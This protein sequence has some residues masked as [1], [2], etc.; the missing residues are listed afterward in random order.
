M[1]FT[2][3]QQAA[4]D[5]IASWDRKGKF[6]LRGAAGTGKSTLMKEVI[7]DFSS[8][9]VTLLAPTGK[10]CVRL[11][12]TTGQQATTIHSA[13]Y[14]AFKNRR[15]ELK[16]S[17]RMDADQGGVAIVDE[18]SMVTER[19]ASDLE[20][21]FDGVLYIGDHYQLPPVKAA[22]WFGNQKAD[23]ELTEVLRQALDSPILSL[24]TAIR[25]GKPTPASCVSDE[26]VI[27]S[28]ATVEDM[29]GVDQVI[30][31]TNK[32]REALNSLMRGKLGRQGPIQV[33]DRLINLRNVAKGEQY[34]CNG[35]QGVVV[36]EVG[37]KWR[38]LFDGGEEVVCPI[39]TD[40][41]RFNQKY[42]ESG[43]SNRGSSSKPP[44]DLL[45]VDMA[46][47]VTGHKSQGSQWDSVLVYDDSGYMKD[48]SERRKW[49]Y[50]ALSRAA[51][52][53]VWI[54]KT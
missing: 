41:S 35:A 39:T 7:K 21:C 30:C 18:A 19:M 12:E 52:R 37:A 43:G 53:L 20:K 4:L 3:S 27:K 1:E 5:A 46:Y 8:S 48:A 14:N 54:R 25:Q 17:V 47:C 38:I 34:I 16:F 49:I 15:G 40:E 36:E 42:E 9:G 10:A 26:L 23:A 28:A 13:I 22:D 11:T 6:T 33:G 45:L 24:V 44:G 51:K 32:S 31:A 29:L 50:T 2:K